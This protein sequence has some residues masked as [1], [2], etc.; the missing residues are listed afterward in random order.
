M[1]SDIA[2]QVGGKVLGPDIE[3]STFSSDTRSL[4]S[5]DVFVALVGENFNG[6]NFLDEA[7]NKGAA[8]AIVS[9]EVNSEIPVI[10][11]ADVH[12]A[13]G[14]IASYV[15]KRS[16]ATLIGVTGSQGKTTVKEMIGSILS[17]QSTTLITKAN[18]NNTIG[19]PLTLLQLQEHH[20][21]AVIEMGADCHGEI[22]FSAV[23]SSPD[24]ALITNANEA[25]VEGFGSLQG[26]V[27]AK[28]EIIDPTVVNGRIILNADDSNVKEWVARAGN[29]KIIKFSEYNTNVGYFASDIEIG[30]DGKVNFVLNTPLASLSITLKLLGRH[31]VINA[32][33][34]A[35]ASMEGGAK[36]VHVKEGL[37]SLSPVSGRLT[38][39]L[40]LNHC[41]ILDDTYNASPT[42]FKAAIDVLMSFSGQ[43]I[44][45][46]GDMKELGIETEKLHKEIG[47]YAAQAGVDELW[48]V[49]ALSEFTVQGFG[50][51]ARHFD[52]MQKLI[53]TC[54]S[55]ASSSLVFL[56]K[57]SRGSHMELVV[58]S[59]TMREGD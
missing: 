58:N 38:P 6:I 8:A 37:E 40:G 27:E 22:E 25:H 45:L 15:R 47:K 18:F 35:A 43:K 9:E 20:E 5:G 33:A 16:K 12:L 23:M 19:V 39:L 4:K 46:A 3:V 50:G 54:R 53:D 31:N 42:S 30:S 21:Y 17:K 1:L 57:G 14:K 52:D 32:V 26:I 36:L 48:A 44:L 56:V 24:I 49:G 51:N 13:L 7:I 41:R 59:L 34:A 11:V 28:G 10:K 2:I 29:R 55:S